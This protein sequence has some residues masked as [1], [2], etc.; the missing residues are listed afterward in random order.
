MFG[1]SAHRTRLAPIRLANIRGTSVDN[2]SPPKAVPE[3]RGD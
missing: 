2:P 1:A 3:P